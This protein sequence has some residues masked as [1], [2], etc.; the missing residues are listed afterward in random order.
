MEF[1]NGGDLYHLLKEHKK[2]K[3]PWTENEL[4]WFVFEILMAVDYLH[5]KNI[6]HRDIKT[7]N[8]F[9]SKDRHIK[10]G[11]LGVST[12][13]NSIIPLQGTRIGTPLYLAPELIKQQ[14][15]SFK[16]D[17]WAIGWAL[18]HLCWFEPPFIGT[19]LI[20]L[21]NTIVNKKPK[22]LPKN[23][24]PSFSLFL[25]KLLAK[26]PENRPTARNAL[27]LIP[28]FI[29]NMDRYVVKSVE[30]SNSQCSEKNMSI[31]PDM[32]PERRQANNAIQQEGDFYKI[33]PISAAVVRSP[34]IRMKE[35][36]KDNRDFKVC[37]LD[38]D[39]NIVPQKNTNND[40]VDDKIVSNNITNQG[41]TKSLT[42]NKQVHKRLLN[43]RMSYEDESD[44][45]LD[46][47]VLTDKQDSVISPMNP[48]IFCRSSQAPS[49]KKPSEN[50][51]FQ[52]P[53]ERTQ[54]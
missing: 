29:K 42:M 43:K 24:S 10:L 45:G 22:R 3:I 51:P 26:N 16:V 13:V 23:Y 25:E 47:I 27:K 20:V 8:I 46:K 48:T 34:N 15:Y 44:G 38:D 33:R 28:K 36:A 49:N 6:I 54:W 30:D 5:S 53:W 4:W 7:L 18:Y 39:K 9:T 37:D 31:P 12:I 50:T 14:P 32:S 52:K 41:V 17:I 35:I 11:D 21:G 40:Y 1:A 2:K 19:N